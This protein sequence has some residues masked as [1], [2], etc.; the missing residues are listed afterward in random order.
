[1]NAL[2]K[3][4]ILIIRVFK[5]LSMDAKELGAEFRWAAILCHPISDSKNK[6]VLRLSTIA[7]GRIVSLNRKIGYIGSFNYKNQTNY[8][9]ER[10]E[11]QFRPECRI[12]RATTH[13][14]ISH[15]VTCGPVDTSTGK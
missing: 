6:S 4:F 15:C 2:R 5:G 10:F 9:L 8:L 3:E 1:M 12:D 11:R 14:I 7:I 13:N